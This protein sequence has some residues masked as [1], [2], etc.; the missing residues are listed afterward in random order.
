MDI[1]GPMDDELRRRLVEAHNRLPSSC[2]SLPASEEALLAHERQFGPIP[3]DYRWFLKAC[4]GGVIGSERVNDLTELP[5]TH[6]KFKREPWT[7]KD[8][9]VIGWD[10]AGNPFGIEYRT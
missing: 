3:S 10:G 8:V 1:I 5:S 9:Y 7:M 2:R 6:A 4:G